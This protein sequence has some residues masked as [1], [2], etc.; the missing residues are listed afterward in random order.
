MSIMSDSEV[1]RD[2]SSSFYDEVELDDSPLAT[3][4]SDEETVQIE[5]KRK[6]FF[7]INFNVRIQ[8]VKKEN[9]R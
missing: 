3:D 7:D 4:L 2:K 6:F 5:I 1:Q 9:N 8:N